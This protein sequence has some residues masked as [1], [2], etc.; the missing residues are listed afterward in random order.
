M[1]GAGAKLPAESENRGASDRGLML[2]LNHIE[3]D[4]LM[5]ICI[6]IG[7]SIME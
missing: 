1:C 5:C 6:F 7:L 3:G 2:Y 4:I